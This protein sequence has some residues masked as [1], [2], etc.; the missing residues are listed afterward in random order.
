MISMGRGRWV[1]ALLATHLAF[2]QD[3]PAPPIPEIRT[4]STLVIVPAL[5]RSASGELLLGLNANDFSITDN[6]V[7][8]KVTLEEVERQPVSILVVMQTGG[9]GPRQFENYRNLPILLDAMGG[10]AKH[11]AAVMTF[12]SAPED[13]FPFVSNTARLK[14]AFTHPHEG[15]HG[16]AVLDAVNYAI[17]LF[18]PKPATTRR[19]I[20]LLSQPQDD[21]SKVHAEEVVRR[22][23]ENNITIFSVSFSPEKSWLKD[24]FTKPRQGNAPYALPA[25]APLLNTFNL[26][27][28]L[29][30][31]LRAMREDTAAEVASLSGGEHVRFDDTRSLEEQLALI[32]NQIPNRYLLSFSP[33]SSAP[34]FHALK[35]QVKGQADPVS[36]SARTG[37]WSRTKA[38]SAVI[39]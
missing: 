31:A 17:D 11:E 34:G 22:L 35:V 33:N 29:V 19:I 25:H 32:A 30:V 27:T 13:L 14:E 6:G 28:P 1:A 3:S 18:K 26:S 7:E 39:P 36:V 20:L 38:A 16:A 10:S 12:D 37:Y 2:A 21:G 9:A 15:D 5:V 23:G 24:Q 8:Q 4:T